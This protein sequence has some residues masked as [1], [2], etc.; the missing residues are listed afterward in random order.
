MNTTRAKTLQVLT[1]IWVA[2]FGLGLVGLILRFATG[3]RLV[4]YGSYVPWGLWVALY[5]H[6]VGIAGGVFAIGVLGWLR[7]VPGLREQLRVTLWVSAAALV[8]GLFAI[9]LDLGHPWRGYRM[10]TA[11]S[12]TSMMAFNS[13]MYGAFLATVAAAFALASRRTGSRM[14]GDAAGWL[15]PMLMLGLVMAVAFPSQSGAFFGVVDAKPYWNTSLMPVLFL[16]SAVASGAAVLL[17]VHT[18][19][20]GEGARVGAEPLRL[21]RHVTIAAVVVYLALEFAE[22]SVAFWSPAS[23]GREAYQLVLAGPFWWVFWIVHLGGALA[24]LW[25]LARGRSLPAVGTGAFLVALTFV[26]TRLNILI[27]GQAVSE[28]RGLEGA[29]THPRLSFH[30]QA[31]WNEYLVALFLG[32]FGVGLVHAGLVRYGRHGS[33]KEVEAR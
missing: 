11:P 13:W 8:T 20:A 15:A 2:A 16:A 22:F 17:L 24:A 31:T 1:M 12:F 18:F 23:H 9:W 19:L 4:G 29:F 26:T 21:L 30:Y 6:G 25:L 14:P 3:E 32:A 7:G 5:F 28:L 33:G 27:P 10:F